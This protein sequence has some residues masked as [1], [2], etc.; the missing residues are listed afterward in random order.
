MCDFPHLPGYETSERD[1]AVT[2]PRSHF[3]KVLSARPQGRFRGHG[4]LLSVVLGGVALL[5]ASSTVLANGGAGSMAVTARATESPLQVELTWTRNAIYNGGAS[6]TFHSIV[7]YRRVHGTVTPSLLATITD[8]TARS[9]VDN[10]VERGILYEYYV[11]QRF[12]SPSGGFGISSPS[13]WVSSGISVPL[14]DA[15]GRVLL[16]VDETISSVLAE[17]ISLFERSLIGSG[18]KTSRSIVPRDTNAPGS[19]GTTTRTSDPRPTKQVI[20]DCLAANPDLKAVI[21][22]GRVTIPF[23]G[24]TDPDGHGDR[25]HSTDSYYADIN[26]TWEDVVNHSSLSAPRNIPGDLRWDTEMFA[27]DGE[28]PGSGRELMVGRIDFAGMTKFSESEVQLL[29]RYFHKNH[30]FR[31]GVTQASR[32]GFWTIPI[33]YDFQ[34]GAISNMS[35]YFGGGAVTSRGTSDW[36]QITANESFLWGAAGA[37]GSVESTT[38]INTDQMATS[39]YKVVFAT[40]GSSYMMETWRNNSA[41]RGLIAMPTWGIASVV[42]HSLYGEMTH[43]GFSMGRPLGE[44]NLGPLTRFPAFFGLFEGFSLPSKTLQAIYANLQGDPTVTMYV[45]LP[46]SNLRIAVDGNAAVLSW[47]GST[48]AN[49]LGYHIYRSNGWSSPFTRLTTEPVIGTTFRDST[50]RS[51]DVIYMVRAVNLET[52]GTGTYIAAS[53]GVFAPLSLSGVSNSAPTA[54]SANVSLNEDS[55][56]VVNPQGTDPENDQLTTVIVRPPTQGKLL[57]EGTGYRYIPRANFS[58]NDSFEFVV[59]D[60]YQDSARVTSNI[61]VNAFSFPVVQNSRPVTAMNRNGNEILGLTVN[62]SEIPRQRLQTG[63]LT[64]FAGA[65]AAVVLTSNGTSPATGS[66]AQGFLS[67]YLFDTGLINLA[68]SPTAVTLAFSPPLVNRP[69]PDIVAL[70]VHA[71]SPP[72]P[73][74]IHINGETR[75]VTSGLFGN[76]GAATTNAVVRATRTAANTSEA[77]MT[78]LAAFNAAPL[79]T[80]TNNLSQPVFGVAL[81]LSDFAVPEGASVSTIQLGSSPGTTF[82]PVFIAG[83]TAANQAPVAMATATPGSGT[84]PLSVTWSG[85][86]STDSDGSIS[87]Y[88]WTFSDGGTASGITVNRSYAQPGTYSATLTVTDNQGAI[89]SQTASITVLPASTTTRG[90]P[91]SWLVNR[92]GTAADYEAVDATDHDGDGQQTWLEYRA[93]TNPQSSTDAF[94]IV[95]MN[96]NNNGTITLEWR[97]SSEHGVSTPFRVLA[98]S[99]LSGGNWQVRGASVPRA[100]TGNTIWTD[101]SPPSGTRF[102]YRIEAP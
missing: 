64:S 43:P 81:D 69:G 65:T 91:V 25:A 38:G 37:V 47:N 8:S 78:S 23:S 4:F 99:D 16:L 14:E 59:N 71:S 9:Y 70:E 61:T 100:A 44:F 97:G 41:I 45:T 101:P 33:E 2:S 48:E 54:L 50:T 36:R 92:F 72:D 82:D 83:I 3:P 66:Q 42:S 95:N 35:S 84:A 68:T 15:P 18:W 11:I 26:E 60:G 27:W 20:M 6:F 1:L 86:L 53:Q 89:A 13:T 39:D 57:M 79:A 24:S 10:S 34:D 17:R 52:R 22:I 19:A 93:G 51:S 7:I 85:A 58:G 94:R 88:S 75:Q 49:L 32:R 73:F 90:T 40:A 12:F 30:A 56:V 63:T 62:G 102:F 80:S 96:V 29:D 77:I 31:Y 67:D 87:S 28:S 74:E 98:T 46:P 5:S 76:T 55:T 21:L